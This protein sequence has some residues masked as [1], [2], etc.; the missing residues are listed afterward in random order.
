[1]ETERINEL[2]SEL[3]SEIRSELL[4]SV[5]TFSALR[6]VSRGAVAAESV[7]DAATFEKTL[8]VLTAGGYR[9][10]ANRESG[11]NRFAAL[12]GGNR[13]LT[14]GLFAVDGLLRVTV[15]QMPR[16]L[17]LGAQGPARY[18]AV[19]LTQ[20][21]THTSYSTRVRGS[22]S[23]MGYV[24]R[25]RDGRLIVIDGGFHLAPDFGDDYPDFRDLL[26]ELS[27]GERP[28]VALWVLTHAHVDHYGLLRSWKP[29]DAEIGA[30]LATLPPDGI[31][32]AAC[33]DM[34][35]SVPFFAEKTVTAHTGDLFD[36]GDV[37]LE[38]FYTCE[39]LAWS[40]PE[41]LSRDLNNQSLIFAVR[42]G[43]EQILFT[44][45]AR[46][47]ALDR[48]ARTAGERIQSAVCQIPH[49]GRTVA[50][51]N[52]A[53]SRISP[54]VALWPA[55]RT[56]IDYD[57]SHIEGVNAWIFGADSTVTDHFV[58]NDGT[59][60]LTLPYRAVGRPYRKEENEC[61]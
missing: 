30:Y 24:L 34:A 42:T 46:Y 60:T 1:M 19:T 56:Q 38:V 52:A 59:V 28:Q 40:N 8:A 43:G 45:D 35:E 49:H 3:R 33:A 21:A 53:M 5:G 27:G 37:Q 29:E 10:T 6:A 4:S 51:D 31:S 41:A 2:R 32:D 36:F 55:C 7:G 54:K 39:D 20:F 61:E 13:K 14:V 44:G 9:L 23:G 48:A 50:G 17:M 15:E 22:A 11:G 58:A 25:L 18:P 26:R 57:S 47:P 12:S 16:V